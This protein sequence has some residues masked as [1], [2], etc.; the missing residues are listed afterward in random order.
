[1]AW[2]AAWIDAALRSERGHVIVFVGDLGQAW[3]HIVEEPRGIRRFE[4][5]RIETAAPLSMV[6]L[7]DQV[8]R[9][10]LPIAD[11]ALAAIMT[12]T[13]GFLGPIGQWTERHLGAR[14]DQRPAGAYPRFETLP[15]AGRRM[16]RALIEYVQ[17]DDALDSDA[18][19]D[20]CEG[21]DPKRVFDWL[22]WTGLAEL[23]VGDGEQLRLNGVFWLEGVRQ[24]LTAP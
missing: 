2:D 12:E 24:L 4:N 6:E 3:L 10:R 5:A 18:L 15:A 20:A 11:D 8:R 19:R 14:R 23:V 17:P 16:M 22:L 21:H 13:G 9:R 7:E 1:V